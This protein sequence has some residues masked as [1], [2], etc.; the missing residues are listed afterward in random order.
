[1][2]KLVWTSRDQVLML[3]FLSNVS[4]SAN[5]CI[6]AKMNERVYNMFHLCLPYPYAQRCKML[7]DLVW[8]RLWSENFVRWLVGSTH[9]V[10]ILGVKEKHIALSCTFRHLT[11]TYFLM[12]KPNHKVVVF[13]PKCFL[14]PSSSVL[15]SKIIKAFFHF[16]I[17]EKFMK[18]VDV[19][20]SL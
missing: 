5:G 4:A 10:E 12:N 1:M 11:I 15:R 2:E 19:S 7:I 20:S 18:Q 13:F 6:W 14:P 8:W 17:K 3:S 16:Y 9:T